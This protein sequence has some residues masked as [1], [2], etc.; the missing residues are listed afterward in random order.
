MVFCSACHALP[1]PA[2]FPQSVWYDEVK[3]GFDFYYQSGRKDL[4]PPPVQAV[5]EYFRERAPK[6]LVVPSPAPEPSTSRLR[7]HASVMVLPKSAEATKPA[8]ISFVCQWPGDEKHS[9]SLLLSDMAGGGVWRWQPLAA[10]RP[11]QHVA[12]LRNPAAA[13]FVDLNGNGEPDLVVV[14]L[15]SFSPADHDRGASFGCR[16]LARQ[17]RCRKG[18]R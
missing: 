1:K 11:P 6:S 17:H 10:D 16:M 3:R 14:D 5:V 12:L 15:G 4:S 9:K 7:F 2:S 13:R 18:L 8:A